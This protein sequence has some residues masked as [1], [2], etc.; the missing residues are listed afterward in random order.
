M[1]SVALPSASNRK[2]KPDATRTRQPPNSA[3]SAGTTPRISH[4]P[5]R[6]RPWPGRERLDKPSRLDGFR[7]ARG[8]PRS[9][10]ARSPALRLRPTDQVRTGSDG[11]RRARADPRVAGP[12]HRRDPRRANRRHRKAGIPPRTRRRCPQ[13]AARAPHAR[14]PPPPT[15]FAHKPPLR[16]PSPTASP[17]FGGVRCGSQPISIQ[18]IKTL[19]AYTTGFGARWKLRR[20]RS[21]RD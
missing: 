14:F 3:H 5:V 7:G 4:G 13:R 16:S 1:L 2:P 20:P 21:T 15:S 11:N 10:P 18:P 17:P 12:A 8:P 19:S 6:H 9:L